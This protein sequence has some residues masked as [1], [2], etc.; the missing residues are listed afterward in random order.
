MQ[1]TTKQLFSYPVAIF[2]LGDTLH[3]FFNTERTNQIWLSNEHEHCFNNFS[4]KSINVL[5]Q[6][7]NEQD[8]LL[9]CVYIYKNEIMQW[10]NSEIKITTSWLTKTEQGGFSKSH[11]HFNSLI[12][13]VV[14]DEFNGCEN[15]G[16]IIFDSPKQQSSILPCKP[17]NYTFD[18]CTDAYIRAQP[19]H[20]I[21]FESTLKH[22]IARHN[23]TQTRF[24]L[25]FNTFPIGQIGLHDSSLEIKI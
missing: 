11:S 13:G 4:S 16:E 24:S 25:A 12:S 1:I 19:N 9:E 5:A 20:L 8:K 23:S 21:L 6:Y 7:K 3:N 10:R 18:N 14:Y 15:V 2:N 22:H 17:S